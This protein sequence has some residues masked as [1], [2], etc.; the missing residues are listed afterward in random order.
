MN[1]AEQ[2]GEQR[3]I[4]IGEKRGEQRGEKRGEKIGEQR[5]EKNTKISFALNLK[6]N[7]FSVEEIANYA[8]LPE[9]EVIKILEEHG[10]V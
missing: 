1:A 9:E 3:G 8:M 2:R 5:G 10:Q 4:A 6:R 7:G